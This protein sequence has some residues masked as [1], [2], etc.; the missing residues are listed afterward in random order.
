MSIRSVLVPI[1]PQDEPGP[2]LGAAL[3]IARRFDGHL[4]ALFIASDSNEFPSGLPALTRRDRIG[5]DDRAAAA[6]RL[7]AVA[8]EARVEDWRAAAVPIGEAGHA[9]GVLKTATR[10]IE[11]IGAIERVLPAHGRLADLIVLHYPTRHVEESDRMFTVATFATGR[12]VL[13][14]RHEVPKDILRHILVAWNG[15]LEST[16]ALAGAMPLL[17]AAGSV[18]IFTAPP[19]D[20]T[21]VLGPSLCE[22]LARHGIHSQQIWA[23]RSDAAVGDALLRAAGERGASMIVMG[24]QNHSRHLPSQFGGITRH[25]LHDGGLP[26]L[27]AH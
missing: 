1:L 17:A 7:A 20:G 12:P 23:H 21:P 18:T 19:P 13:L 11:Q 4:D 25:V 2:M 9:A 3:Q 24:A 8:S 15:G 5:I 26:V 10:W 14:V 6:R 27:M 16:R 22:A